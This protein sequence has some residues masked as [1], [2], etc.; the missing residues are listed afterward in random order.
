MHV[1]V[2][3][4][5]QN[6]AC[7]LWL[8][9][10]TWVG[11]Y[12]QLVL[13]NSVDTIFSSCEYVLVHTARFGL[14]LVAEHIT[15][16]SLLTSFLLQQQIKWRSSARCC[17]C[18]TWFTNKQ[19]LSLCSRVLLLMFVFFLLKHYTWDSKQLQRAN[20]ATVH[21]GFLVQQKNTAVW[22]LN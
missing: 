18:L 5:M 7:V 14:S 22:K 13:M 19:T 1:M 17:I 21:A 8:C 16:I 6:M 12:S 2:S 11:F 15:G 9:Q 3:Y 20:F 10:F 4:I